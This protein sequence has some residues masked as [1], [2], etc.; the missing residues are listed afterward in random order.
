MRLKVCGMKY[1]DNITDVVAL[2]PEYLGFI[3]YERSPRNFV[4]DLAQFSGS[5]KKVGVFVDAS[6]AKIIDICSSANLDL[7]QLH[8]DETPGYCYDLRDA[9]ESQNSDYHIEL[10]K[11]FAVDESFDFRGLKAYED[12]VDYFLFD[13][14][15][16]LPGGNG[17]AFDW[18]L[19]ADYNMKKPFFLSGGIGLESVEDLKA[20]MASE[21]S[22]YCHAIDIN[23][24][25][26]D[27]PGLKNIKKLNLFKK[28][29]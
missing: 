11:A 9:L 27:K 2:E 25:F 28:E 20:F 10:I 19:I 18:N 12:V 5:Y 17:I 14:K 23:S 26:E 21:L 8:G 1:Q 7:I 24:R 15:G 29:L 22:A 3:F 4:G 16:K 13:T 6:A